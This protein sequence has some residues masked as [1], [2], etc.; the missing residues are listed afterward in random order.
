MLKAEQRGPITEPL[1]NGAGQ[2]KPECSLKFYLKKFFIKRGEKIQT[3]KSP[4]Y[5]SIP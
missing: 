5:T 4:D 3:G 2:Q 1:W